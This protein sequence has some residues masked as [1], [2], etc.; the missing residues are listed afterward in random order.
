MYLFKDVAEQVRRYTSLPIWWS[1]YYTVGYGSNVATQASALYHMLRGGSAVA[2][3]WNPLDNGEV[4]H[5]IITDVKLPGGGQPTPSYKI[6]HAFHAYFGPGTPFYKTI[7]SSSDIE[8]L[9]SSKKTM[10]I[11][12]RSESIPV[13]LNNLLVD[14]PAYGIV[15]INTP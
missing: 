4:S 13:R 6:F 9:A 2:L 3:L 15:V 10:L 14:V 5:G 1:E 11:N 8:V 12:K 7:T